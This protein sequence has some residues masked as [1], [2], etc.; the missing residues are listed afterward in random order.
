MKLNRFKYFIHEYLFAERTNLYTSL[1][2]CL[3]LASEFRNLDIILRGHAP[4]QPSG[5]Y[6]STPAA[7]PSPIVGLRAFPWVVLRTRTFKEGEVH[8]CYVGQFGCP[9]DAFAF[10]ELKTAQAKRRR[11]QE[12]ERFYVLLLARAENG[13]EVE[14]ARMASN[15]LQQLYRERDRAARRK[16]RLAAAA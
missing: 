14:L 15:H 11:D 7:A 1:D 4:W 5:L 10:A 13:C 6:Q 16:E 12:Y 8:R 2:E 9:R 3:V